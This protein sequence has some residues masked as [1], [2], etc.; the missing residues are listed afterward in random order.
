MAV[1]KRSLTEQNGTRI[2]ECELDNSDIGA[3]TSTPPRVTVRIHF[4][5]PPEGDP[6]L[7][8]ALEAALR[9]ALTTID[10]EIGRIRG[11]R[12]EA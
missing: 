12:G 8:E 2:L 10:V 4:A 3:P 7:P 5:C 9:H 1:L 11:P 6:P